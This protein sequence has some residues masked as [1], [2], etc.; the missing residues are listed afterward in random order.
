MFIDNVEIPELE[1]TKQVDLQKQQSKIE[2]HQKW[3]FELL[4][5]LS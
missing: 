5:R 2:E 1:I 3:K 4:M